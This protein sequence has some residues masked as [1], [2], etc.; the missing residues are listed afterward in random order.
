MTFRMLFRGVASTVGLLAVVSGSLLLPPGS[1][2]EAQEDAQEIPS[3][4][5]E[6]FPALRIYVEGEILAVEDGGRTLRLLAPGSDGHL[7]GDGR[8]DPRAPIG[9][10]G[11]RGSPGRKEVVVSLRRVQ[12]WLFIDDEDGGEQQ[13]IR[14]DRGREVFA[15]GQLVEIAPAPGLSSGVSEGSVRSQTTAPGLLSGSGLVRS[16]SVKGWVYIRLNRF[17][18]AKQ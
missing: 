12:G 3:G 11:V 10:G 4:V 15:P 7:F 6:H 5:P 13:R 8:S 17:R 1:L 9:S 18:Q 16:V 2:A 14:L